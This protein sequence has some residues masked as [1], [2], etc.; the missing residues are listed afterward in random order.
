MNLVFCIYFRYKNSLTWNCEALIEYTPPCNGCS[1]CYINM[2]KNVAKRWYHRFMPAKKKVDDYSHVINENCKEL[3][4][5][6]ILTADLSLLTTN[7]VP[8]D[9]NGPPKLQL[10]LG[11]CNEP[12][13][14]SIDI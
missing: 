10:Q 2:D 9:L 8:S 7:A 14:R 13:C 6:K 4:E 11:N 1:N 5:K 12:M 3:H